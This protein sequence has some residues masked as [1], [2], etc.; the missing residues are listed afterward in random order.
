M[1]QNLYLQTEKQLFENTIYQLLLLLLD[2]LKE[3]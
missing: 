2:V 1:Q 3:E